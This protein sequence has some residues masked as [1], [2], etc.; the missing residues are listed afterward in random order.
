MIAA[1]APKRKSAARSPRSTPYDPELL[2]NWSL[3]KLRDAC[4]AKG[5]TTPSSARRSL[6]IR[7][8]KENEAS[9]A[10]G[11]SRGSARRSSTLRRTDAQRTSVDSEDEED[12][13][14]G[15][16]P[17]RQVADDTEFV[18]N[19]V[20]ESLESL[21]KRMDD[22]E[23]R[24]TAQPA[25]QLA[26]C[27]SS[28]VMPS[29]P[30]SGVL[31]V[32]AVNATPEHSDIIQPQ[33]FRD[34]NLSSAYARLSSLSPS[35]AAG[36]PAQMAG[37]VAVSTGSAVTTKYGY[38]AQSLPEVVS[39][40]PALRQAIVQGK[41]IN[42]AALLIPYFRGSGD[43]W[44][45]DVRAPHKPLSIAQFIEAFSQYKAIMCAA[46]P[47]RRPELDAYERLIVAM[48]A[49]H[50]G[51]A[52]YEYHCQFSQKA[53][54]Y[55]RHE[56]IAIDWSIRDEMLYNDIFSGR[57]IH[58]CDNCGSSAHAS[59][60]CIFDNG[61]YGPGPPS[62]QPDRP[63]QRSKS[64]DVHGRPRTFHNNKEVCNNF[65]SNSGCRANSCPRAH[66]C[67][68]CKGDHGCTSC[69]LDK[70]GPPQHPK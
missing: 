57:P 34:F 46:F 59:G 1:M 29:S 25:Q 39:V 21:H 62:R 42:L 58:T 12:H 10:G 24:M 41:D 63:Q 66:V 16:P 68:S 4:I 7:L 32:A 38:V 67:S 28:N 6:L 56:N 70:T 54:A 65:N 37:P 5:L 23:R 55:L 15:A 20:M 9:G 48:S 44:D 8:L 13:S 53:A 17:A 50:K 30:R 47:Q 3:T 51:T 36:S 43:N 69:P 22:M 35:A 27:H 31:T 14:N 11:V 2:V 33:N 61:S 26:N 49:R 45:R 64:V 40:S 52:F 18:L 60:F 19:S